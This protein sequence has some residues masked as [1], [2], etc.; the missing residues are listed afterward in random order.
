MR[1]A[2]VLLDEKGCVLSVNP[3]AEKLLQADGSCVGRDFLTVDR[4]HEVSAAIARAMADGR[5]EVR[6]ERGGRTYQFDITPHRFGRR[7]RGRG[8]AVRST[9]P[10]RS[11][12]SATAASLPRTYRTS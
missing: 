2:L 7:G 11:T 9:S 12:P 1:E 10:S 5:G 3:A 8:A 4:S 6:C